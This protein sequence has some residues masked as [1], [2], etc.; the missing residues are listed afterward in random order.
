MAWN[1]SYPMYAEIFPTRYR[2]TGIGLAVAVGRVGG[3]IAP[4]LLAYIFE[5][6]DGNNIFASLVVVASFFLLTCLCS[7]PFA[8]YGVEAEGKSLEDIMEDKT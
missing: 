2:S 6:G 7:I 5:M 8:I 3:F 1:T 4:L